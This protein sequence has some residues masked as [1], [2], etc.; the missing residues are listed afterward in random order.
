[1]PPVSYVGERTLAI[2]KPDAVYAGCVGAIISMIENE[3]FDI[4]DMQMVHLTKD[5]WKEFYKA[6]KGKHFYEANA[7]FMASGTC[8]MMVLEDEDAVDRFR[9]LMGPYT[10]DEPTTIRYK[11]GTSV[12]HNAVHGSDSEESAKFEIDFFYSL[13]Y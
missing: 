12:R 1:M 6:H 8:V 5:Y 10:N 4:V 2:I 11:F 13:N 3:G 7:E 9:K